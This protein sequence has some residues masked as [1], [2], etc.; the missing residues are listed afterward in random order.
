[1]GLTGQDREE[2]VARPGQDS[3]EGLPDQDS[4]DRTARTRL[5]GQV[6]QDGTARKG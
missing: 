2:R 6:S 1:M 5:P 3:Q 4:Q